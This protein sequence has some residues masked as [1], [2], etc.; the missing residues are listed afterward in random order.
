MYNHGLMCIYIYIYIYAYI[1]LYLYMCMHTNMYA[2]LNRDAHERAREIFFG[3]VHK[4][5]MYMNICI[6]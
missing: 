3:L 4:Q 5:V 1:Y 2:Q 6:C